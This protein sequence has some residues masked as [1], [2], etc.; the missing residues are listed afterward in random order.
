MYLRIK[1]QRVGQTVKRQT[2]LTVLDPRVEC[3]RRWHGHAFINISNSHILEI[4]R[5]NN[6]SLHTHIHIHTTK[7]STDIE[8][9]AQIA[10]HS[11]DWRSDVIQ[12]VV[13]RHRAHIVL[14]VAESRAAVRRRAAIERFAMFAA[15]PVQHF[16]HAS[17]RDLKAS[18]RIVR[19]HGD[20]ASARRVHQ[21]TS[22][23]SDWRHGTHLYSGMVNTQKTRVDSYFA[24]CAWCVTT[25]C[26]RFLGRRVLESTLFTLFA[27]EFTCEHKY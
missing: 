13:E 27:T 15:E 16:H 12:H 3:A 7:H 22:V 8:T 14:R 18:R 6:Q 4:E 1:E 23:F 5:K 17:G 10:Q 2:T 9:N 11:A 26:R 19:E 24:C 20:G 25:S 21:H